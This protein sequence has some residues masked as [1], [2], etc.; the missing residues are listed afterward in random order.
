MLIEP[1]HMLDA[2][3]WRRWLQ[4]ALVCS[5]LAL[6]AAVFAA[7]PLPYSVTITP[8]GHAPLDQALADASLLAGLRE[9]APVGP[10]ALLTRAESDA[11]RFD[12]VLRSFGYYDGLIDTLIAGRSSNDPALLEILEDL[13]PTPAVSVTVTIDPGPLYRLG[14]VRLDLMQFEGSA[15][16]NVR[17]AFAL[18]PGEPARAATVLAA[19]Q[20]VLDAL[21]EDGFAL[22]Q[23]PP[24]DA[25]VDHNTRTMDVV[26]TAE[27]GP[28]VT[29]GAISI[30]GLTGLREDAVRRRLGLTPG[31]PFSP[32]RL[33][34][35][36][37]ALL[38]SGVLAWARLTPGTVPDVNGRLPLTLEVAERPSRVVRFA[39]SFSSDE[40]A[41]LST[42]WT[43]R[44]LFGG[45]EQLTL[46]GDVGQLAGNRP[47]DMS[48]LVNAALRIP[49]I[50]L[51]DLDLRLDLGAVREDLDAYDRDAVT[52]GIALERR[53]SARLSASAG[54]AYERARISQDAPPQDY[55]LFSLPLNLSY[56]STDNPLDPLRGLRIG[57]KLIPTQVLEGDADGFLLGRLAGAGY[58]DL[59]SLIAVIAEET[60]AGRSVLAGRLVLG[61]ILGADA[62]EVPPDWRFYA[63]GGG[64]VRGYPFQSIGPR[65]P[66]GK[67]AGGDGLLEAGLELRQRFG[68]R[69]G[70]AAFVD[71][72]S[73][74]ENALPGS[75]ELA[76]GVGLGVRYFTPVGPLRVDIATPLDPSSGDSPVQL[77]IGIGQAF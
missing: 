14:L 57:A 31:E 53:I 41:T 40:G 75:G 27:P 37:R 6:G 15:P 11:A 76:V 47:D 73:V 10:F 9:R 71:A 63:G 34:A 56:D 12:R 55:Q 58:V 3:E 45:G 46:R 23:V 19:G 17:S 38:S 1:R 39:G 67:P 70:G 77:Y 5:G 49:D 36:R 42:S 74:S 30:I 60:G 59:A 32:S 52:A 48:W 26:Y 8:T 29:I 66:S 4:R 50:W 35:A 24:P 13:P 65:T 25:L 72:G 43:H 18:T 69:W 20:A 33:E 7:D 44:N 16:A 64:S 62:D 2:N 68:V 61:S 22:A 21:Q 51:R 28:H 54:L